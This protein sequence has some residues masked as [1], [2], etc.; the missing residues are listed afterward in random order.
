MK[1]IPS[2]NWSSVRTSTGHTAMICWICH[3]VL[4]SAGD[5]WSTTRSTK[6]NQKG[7]FFSVCFR[8]ENAFSKTL[9]TDEKKIKSSMVGSIKKRANISRIFSVVWNHSICCFIVSIGQ[10][11]QVCCLFDDASTAQP[12][13]IHLFS[14]VSSSIDLISNWIR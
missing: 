7:W 14:I 11:A 13:Y 1:S 9:C 10:R 12:H 2:I 4:L 6:A 3:G 5:A 8:F